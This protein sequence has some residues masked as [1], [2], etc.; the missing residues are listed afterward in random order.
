MV[1]FPQK[2]GATGSSQRRVEALKLGNHKGI[3]VDN[4]N[5]TKENR[6][7]IGTSKTKNSYR[8]N[9][10]YVYSYELK[11]S[12]TFRSEFL[13]TS[14]HLDK[15]IQMKVKMS[16]KRSWGVAVVVGVAKQLPSKTFSRKHFV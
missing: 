13:C 5:N 6:K 11:D 3:V 14:N 10:M 1:K 12:I 2:A 15:S 16:V 4:D 9:C 7:P 8:R